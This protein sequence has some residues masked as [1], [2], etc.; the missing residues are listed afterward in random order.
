MS[1]HG[2]MTDFS[3]Y[4]HEELVRMLHAGR[5]D[6]VRSIGDQWHQIGR[7]LYDR[8]DDITEQLEAFSPYWTGGAAE[9]YKKMMKELAAGI[10]TVAQ[11]TLSTRDLIYHAGEALTQAQAKMPAAVAVTP[12]DATVQALASGTLP[13]PAATALWESAGPA[14]RSALVQQVQQVQAETAAA[15][16][17]HDQ[18]VQVMTE[19]AVNYTATEEAI[20]SPPAAAS[21]PVVVGAGTAA[22]GPVV[23]GQPA[24][25]VLPST[26][27]GQV[28]PANLVTGAGA[29]GSAP[30]QPP[31]FSGVYSSGL[32]AAGAAVAGLFAGRGGRALGRLLKPR[33]GVGK[34]GGKLGGLDDLKGAGAGAGLGGGGSFG[35]GGSAA[36]ALGATPVASPD[37]AAAA[38]GGGGGGG[39]VGGSGITSGGTGAGSAAN[40]G[41]AGGMP[42]MPMAGMGEAGAG[43]RRIPPWLVETED[44]WGESAVVTPPVIGEVAPEPRTPGSR[45]RPGG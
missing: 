8:A 10:R 31:L 6:Q 41:F 12:V 44:V 33:D 29:L 23:P 45:L 9:Q 17:A 40:R 4:S 42:F 25:V 35:G 24:A 3:R 26:Q 20:P 39:G 19:L 18:A 13:A 16:A 30:K 37:L 32:A 43:G 5:P 1:N 21:P 2:Q 22:G 11:T 34:P 38:S 15:N 36:A 28:L 7:G 14:G 27:P